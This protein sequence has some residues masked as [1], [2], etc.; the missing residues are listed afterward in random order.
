MDVHLLGGER[1]T[2]VV[3]PLIRVLLAIRTQIQLW[4]G[5]FAPA[6]V[7]IGTCLASTALVPLHRFLLLYSLPDMDWSPTLPAI[8]LD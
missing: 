5:C 4:F 3:I 6:S 1:S 8:Q 2:V 7:K